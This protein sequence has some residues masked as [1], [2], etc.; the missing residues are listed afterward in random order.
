MN[1]NDV[2]G[3]LVALVGGYVI[4]LGWKILEGL[5]RGEADMPAWA[6]IAATVVFFAG[7]LAAIGWGIS[8]YR[9]SRKEDSQD[10]EEE[11]DRE[12]SRK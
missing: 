7:G 9:K 5:R 3:I 8:L 6:A 4:Y 2:H 12:T 1:R 11:R 10:C